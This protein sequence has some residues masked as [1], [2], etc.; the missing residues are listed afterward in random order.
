M[1]GRSREVGVS[2]REV[3]F[4]SRNQPANMDVDKIFTTLADSILIVRQNPG[5]L[6]KLKKKV[7]AK[8]EA[9]NPDKT[10]DCD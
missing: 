2:K 8:D 7:T 1:E 3:K 5:G 9:E 4:G 6:R 10:D